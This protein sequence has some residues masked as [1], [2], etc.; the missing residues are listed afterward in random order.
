M[1]VLLAESER[2]SARYA[3]MN[4]LLKGEV[5]RLR[6]SL[7]RAKHAHNAEYMKNVTLKV[8]FHK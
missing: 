5:R 8:L 4:E 6:D 1:T 3:Q 2:E 7:E